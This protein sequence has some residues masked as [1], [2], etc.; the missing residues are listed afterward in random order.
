MEGLE[1]DHGHKDHVGLLAALHLDLLD[2]AHLKRAELGLE[3]GDVRLKVNEGLAH[4]C[5]GLSGSS[6][7]R[8]RRAEDLLV[9]SGHRVRWERQRTGVA[10]GGFE[11]K[12]IHSV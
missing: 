1:L 7:R 12:T 5:L 6:V 11:R 2:G 10:N 9:H 4:S 8:I 3:L